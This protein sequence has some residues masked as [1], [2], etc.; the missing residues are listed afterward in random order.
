MF[1]EISTKYYKTIYNYCLYKFSGNKASAENVTQKVFF[2]L[3]K[4]L[5]HIKPQ[6]RNS[7]PA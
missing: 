5:D 4:R 6:R 3:Y 2:S 1:E 7:V